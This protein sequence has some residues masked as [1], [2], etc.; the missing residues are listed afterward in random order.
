MLQRIQLYGIINKKAATKKRSLFIQRAFFY[1]LKNKENVYFGLPNLRA[2]KKNNIPI[3]LV[4]CAN[5][6]LLKT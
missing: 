2:Q 5:T 3:L 4:F 6:A 1:F